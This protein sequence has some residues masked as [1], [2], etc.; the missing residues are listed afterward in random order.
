MTET[1]NTNQEQNSE[2]ENKKVFMVDHKEKYTSKLRSKKPLPIQKKGISKGQK[3]FKAS[4]KKIVADE[5]STFH[6]ME[7]PKMFNS[8]EQYNK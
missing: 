7:E 3:S 1:V 8:F 4:A 6:N 2:I 5:E